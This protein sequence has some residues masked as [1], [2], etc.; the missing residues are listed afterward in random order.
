MGIYK[1]G[2][3]EH[4]FSNYYNAPCRYKGLYYQNAEAAFQSAKTLDEEER[5]KFTTLSPGAA[6]RL[7]RKTLLRDDWEAVKYS[8]MMEVL[9]S[10]F[11]DT[12]LWSLLIETGADI[13]VEN[14]T[15]WHDNVWGN[16]ECPKCADEEGRNLLGKA[17][18]ELRDG[19]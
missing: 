7:G 9:R 4:P 14:T 8:V 1:F 19:R 6:R 16:C 12:E 2:G 17:L 18:M 11:Q 13:I 15:G 10:K 3:R 5:R